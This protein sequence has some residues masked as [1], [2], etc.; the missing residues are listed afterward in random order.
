MTKKV[1]LTLFPS[2]LKGEVKVPPSKS[3]SHRSLICAALSE[4]ESFISNIIYSED[5]TSTINALTQLG[6]KFE[7]FEDYIIVKGVRKLRLKSKYVDCNESGSTLRFLIPLF[8]LTNKEIYFTGKKSLIARPQKI[9]QDI[10]DAE[11]NKFIVNEY[12]IMVKGS[13]KAR[14]YRIKGNV[15]SQFFSGLMFALPLLKED[16]TI[17]IDGELESKS[18][19]DLTIDMLEHFGIEIREIENGYFIE[20]SQS[21][22]AN[23][24]RVEGDFSQAAFFLVGGVLNGAVKVDDLKHDSFQGDKEII[25]IIQDMKGRIIF[26]ENGFVTNKSITSSTTIDLSN[27]P[28]L[29]PIVALLASLSK[30]TTKVINAGRLRIKESDRIES[31]VKSLKALGANITAT[32]NEITIIGRKTLHGGITLDSYNDHRIA[33]MLAIASTRCEKPITITTA[34]AV[35]K[36]YPHFF[37]DFIKIGGIIE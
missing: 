9:Y 19:I 4:G 8:S 14:E 26:T 13:V 30:G 7:L 21:Y 2:S 16:S 5:I 11:Q 18:Y 12:S 25:D 23:D 15:S 27:C 28:D 6:A 17:Y 32:E 31:T 33:M 29:G 24:Y 22:E 37:E 35:N 20:G 36:S 1:D 34:N 3:L 10:F